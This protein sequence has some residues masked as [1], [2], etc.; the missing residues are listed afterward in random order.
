[1]ALASVNG[2]DLYYEDTGG[3]GPPVV[4]SHGLLWSTRMFDAQVAAL[5]DRYRCISFDHRGQGQSPSSPTAYDM[6]M[7]ADDAAALITQLGVAPCHF[8][9]LSMGGMVGMRLAARKP[10]LLR[11]LT[12]IETAGDTE[13][14]RNVPK[15]AAMM[16]AARVAGL[17]PL[18]TPVMRIMFGRAALEDPNRAAE[19]AG[20]EDEL[21]ALPV[22]R[23][24]RAL[25]AVV[26]RRSVMDELGRIRTPTLYLHGEDDRAIAMPRARRTVAA[27]PGARLVI[28][29]RAGHS[30]SRE[31]PAAVSRELT[32]FLATHT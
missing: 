10:A 15:Y 30:S 22:P 12:L 6:E 8:V 32:Q 11:T 19:R 13:P 4:F 7:L 5:R 17:G 9:G 20:W 31:E 25:D 18:V 2:I 23:V 24:E 3:S 21:R 1:M 14:L 27:I 16:L 29:P 28:L 26:K